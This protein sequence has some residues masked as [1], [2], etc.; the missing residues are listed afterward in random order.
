MAA[1]GR[2]RRAELCDGAAIR[3]EL[4]DTR[5]DAVP[6][7]QRSVHDEVRAIH[8]ARSAADDAM[9]D[10]G[11][12]AAGCVCRERALPLFAAEPDVPA[13]AY[14]RLRLGLARDGGLRDLS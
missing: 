14:G 2:W 8:P 9:V 13:V 12:P 5:E 7:R 11:S 10:S 6:R 1:A 3:G 4:A